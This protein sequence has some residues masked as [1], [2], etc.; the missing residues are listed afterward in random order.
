MTRRAAL[1]L[2]VSTARQAE[3]DLSIPDQRRQLEA[4]CR[5]KGWEIVR[6]FVEPGASATDDKRPAFQEM[7]EAACSPERPFDLILVHSFSRFFRDAFQ[8]EFYIRRLMK[9]GVAVV[10]ITQETGDDPMS[11]L[12][13][14]IVAL[15]D[16]YQSKENAKHTLRAMRE[17]ARQGFWNG[18]RPP[19]GYRTVEAEKRGDKIKKRL[20]IDPGEA[21]IVRMIFNLCLKGDGSGPMGV[22]AIADYLNRKAI[23]YREG[24]R[25]ST[26]LVHRILT[27]DTYTGTHHFNRTACKAKEDK[28]ETEW[29]AFSVPTIINQETLA[30]VQIWLDGR[31]PKKTPPRIVNGPTLLT[32][33]AHC[34]ICGGGMTL[35]TGKNGR[36]RYY[37]CSTCARQGKA[38]CP[39]QSVPMELLDQLVVDQLG[40]HVLSPERLK[41]LLE[42][43]MVKVANDGGQHAL[44][45][46]ELRK[47][48]RECELGLGRL[49]QAIEQ[50]IAFLDGQL[51]ERISRLK[52][53]KDELIRLTAMA[54]RR[55]ADPA[56]L[57]VPARLEKFATVMQ[58]R[59]H[60]GPLAFRKAY[61]RLFLARVEV[62]R[63]SGLVRL[64][65]PKRALQE[66]V[67]NLEAI[68]GDEVPSFVREWRPLGDSNPCYRRERA[69]YGVQGRSRK[70]TNRLETL[71]SPC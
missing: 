37:T 8:L 51:K 6:D 1:Y 48:L 33:L 61:L 43:V 13:R 57:L 44:R 63:P 17:N 29:V 16:E 28:P 45:I 55:K 25:F 7:I 23:A 11:D 52:A 30:A 10:S 53:R 64:L 5:N 71:I 46:D 49:Y 26:G 58:D 18:A 32:G 56:R 66:G 4:Y 60:N 27:R 20:E 70:S 14:R 24:R 65:G 22:K 69:V 41:P 62:D 59:L 15:F 3:K 36:Y 12:I 19:Y 9:C 34:S 50:G 2:R 38:A 40:Q 54:E 31:N 21:A 67:T 68:A 42:Q 35:R 39:G 47:E